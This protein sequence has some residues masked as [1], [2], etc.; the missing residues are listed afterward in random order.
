MDHRLAKK[1]IAEVV[2]EMPV[3]AGVYV[4][5]ELGRSEV[6]QFGRHGQG[7]DT[8]FL[9]PLLRDRP[10][11]LRLAR[12]HQVDRPQELRRLELLLTELDHL[13]PRMP[14]GEC[15]TGP[16]SGSA[17]YD[18]ARAGFCV[19]AGARRPARAG[20]RPAVNALKAKARQTQDG[21]QPGVSG[22]P[23][24]R[25]SRRRCRPASGSRRCTPSPPLSHPVRVRTA[26]A[27]P[28]HP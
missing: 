13:S 20:A 5:L 8:Q 22:R 19:S 6:E 14:D 21:A 10:V 18:S 23:A 4:P 28:V 17:S 12:C 9:G 11:V 27:Q 16:A 25:N 1:L 24:P 26:T 2:G 15:I 3:V 7:V